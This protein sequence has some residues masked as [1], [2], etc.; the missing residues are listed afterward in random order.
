MIPNTTTRPHATDLCRNKPT[1]SW[2]A[3]CS[4]HRTISGASS[5]M[6]RSA[7]MTGTSSAAPTRC[8]TRSPDRLP[9]SAHSQSLPYHRSSLPQSWFNPVSTLSRPCLNPASTPTQ[10]W[11]NLA[12][13]LFGPEGEYPCAT[14]RICLPSRLRQVPAPVRH[15]HTGDVSSVAGSAGGR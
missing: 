4:A 12:G 15:P 7:H 13:A 9:A 10:P 1:S 6:R 11:L 2:T 8:A 14:R 3:L 5:P